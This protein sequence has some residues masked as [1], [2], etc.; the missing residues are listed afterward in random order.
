MWAVIAR[1]LLRPAAAVR[2]PALCALAGAGAAL[3]TRPSWEV[4]ASESCC[5]A[6]VVCTCVLAPICGLCAVYAAAT[7]AAAQV[8]ADRKLLAALCDDG[9]PTA[10]LARAGYAICDA[11]AGLGWAEADASLRLA[12]E[13]GSTDAMALRSARALRLGFLR[14][15]EDPEASYQSAA[16][17]LYGAASALEA[18]RRSAGKPLYSPPPPVPLTDDAAAAQAALEAARPGVHWSV[19]FVSALACDVPADVHSEPDAA[20]QLDLCRC[21]AA[22]GFAPAHYPVLRRL[23]GEHSPDAAKTMRDFLHDSSR[24]GVRH[25]VMQA[26][27][28]RGMLLPDGEER[29]NLQVM[30]WAAQVSAT[31]AQMAVLVGLGEEAPAASEGSPQQLTE[32]LLKAAAA[33]AR[34][35]ESSAASGPGHSAALTEAVS[36]CRNAAEGGT[37]ATACARLLHEVAVEYERRDRE[38]GPARH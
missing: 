25:H 35:L 3:G 4:R 38:L 27:E 23:L 36:V 19:H 20:A 18:E 11:L 24:P 26:H 8:A 34:N 17:V 1:R 15:S 33:G 29:K 6:G 14:G 32:N 7:A 12:A 28:V 2:R 30:R 10:C 9:D 5:L 37:G 16:A 13:S 22:R 31:Q 21:A